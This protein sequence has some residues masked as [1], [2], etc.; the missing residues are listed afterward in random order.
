MKVKLCA[1][2]PALGAVLEGVKAKLPPTEPTPPLSV[3]LANVWPKVIAEAVGAVVM[4]GV[5]LLTTLETVATLTG[6]APLLDRT[7]FPL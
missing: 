2:V 6:V 4:V 3:E 5:A 7:K 1:A